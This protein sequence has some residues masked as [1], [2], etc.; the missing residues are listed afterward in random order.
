MLK[1]ELIH[2]EVDLAPPAELQRSI[3]THLQRWGE[4]LRW[5][6]TAVDSGQRKAQIEAVVTLDSSLPKVIRPTEIRTI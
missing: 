3:L 2:T 1:T 4:P 5:A 6:I